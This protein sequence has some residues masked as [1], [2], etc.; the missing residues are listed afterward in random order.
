VHLLRTI[1]VRPQ[2]RIGGLLAQ[3][4]RFLLHFARIEYG[5]YAVEL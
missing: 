1:L 2:P 3:I 4:S 5:F